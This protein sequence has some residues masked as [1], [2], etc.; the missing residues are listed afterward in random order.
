MT[1]SVRQT[2]RNIKVAVAIHWGNCGDT[3]ATAA[4]LL[5]DCEAIPW[6][7]DKDF[8]GKGAR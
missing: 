7:L 4:D 3:A 8:K 5:S 1:W 6:L 2:H